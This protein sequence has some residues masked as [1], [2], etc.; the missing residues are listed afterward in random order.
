M[1]SSL[2][3]DFWLSRDYLS[4][5]AAR[6][7]WV[8]SGAMRVA[9][10]MREPADSINVQSPQVWKC[11]L[12]RDTNRVFWSTTRSTSPTVTFPKFRL[13]K[14]YLHAPPR[15][16]HPRVHISW[17]IIAITY[18]AITALPLQNGRHHRQAHRRRPDE[19]NLLCLCLDEP[20]C[21]AAR[22]ANNFLGHYVLLIIARRRR[23]ILR[24]RLRHAGPAM[25]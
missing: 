16:V 4:A 10:S 22:L 6:P 23:H 2:F 5:I 21:Q 12:A 7:G 17:I 24:H 13:H 20:R 15:Q 11:T 14:P 1:I 18:D 25:G 9:A 8:S 3:P 19:R